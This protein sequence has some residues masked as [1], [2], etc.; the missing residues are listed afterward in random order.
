MCEDVQ[1][2]YVYN[3]YYGNTYLN[4]YC[5][6][7]YNPYTDDCCEYGWIMF[8]WTVFGLSIFLIF[9]CAL[10]AARKRRQRQQQMYMEQ[11]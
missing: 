6:D 1:R 10:I 8:G 3:F 11:M 5:S 9:L 7:G 4:M 2:S